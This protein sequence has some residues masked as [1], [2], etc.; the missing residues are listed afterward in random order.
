MECDEIDTNHLKIKLESILIAMVFV[1]DV[2]FDGDVDIQSS[3]NNATLTSLT[4]YNVIK[5]NDL[6]FFSFASLP[7]NGYLLC[8]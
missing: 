7:I 4:S 2:E 8:D 3:N 6:I 1:V 5:L